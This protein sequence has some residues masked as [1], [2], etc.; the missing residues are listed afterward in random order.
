MNS[1]TS[2]SRLF[3]SSFLFPLSSFLFSLT[4]RSLLL[5]PTT[6]KTHDPDIYLTLSQA[7]FEF[8]TSTPSPSSSTHPSVGLSHS[9]QFRYNR[10]PWRI[11][12]KANILCSMLYISCSNL[13]ALIHYKEILDLE[14]I[15][16][17]YI[18]NELRPSKTIHVRR[19]WRGGFIPWEGLYSV[20]K[21]FTQ[22]RRSTA[23][24]E[25][26]FVK[27]VKHVVVVVNRT[28][29]KKNNERFSIFRFANFFLEGMMMNYERE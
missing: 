24:K 2:I 14:S 25:M 21:L 27:R 11:P 7:T 23:K 18:P 22:E 19:G 3:L 10:T 15:K 12:E 28:Y 17:W 4:D 6:L 1:Q 5:T 26:G 13:S 9:F 29:T 16:L 8:D 20:R